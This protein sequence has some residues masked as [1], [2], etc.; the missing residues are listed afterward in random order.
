M[1]TAIRAL[2][3][4]LSALLVGG[5]LSGC[6]GDG[7]VST[8]QYIDDR[9]ITAKVK[10]KL[11]DDPT[12][13]ARNINVDTY[14]GVVQLSGFVESQQ[15]KDRATEIARSVGGVR[16]VKNDLVIRGS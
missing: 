6:A 16:E 10:A 13:K 14:R 4:V 3:L 15:E 11:V 7:G 1:N 9:A 5:A 12:T 2:P 8:G